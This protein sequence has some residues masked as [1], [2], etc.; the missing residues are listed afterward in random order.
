MSSL[1]EEEN[2]IIPPV[3]PKQN[4]ILTSVDN[5]SHKFGI[6]YVRACVR[7]LHHTV[8]VIYRSRSALPRT[9]FFNRVSWSTILVYTLPKVS[10]SLQ[11]TCTWL[12]VLE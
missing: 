11:E 10:L 12:T 2:S 8:L 9:L 3:C 6:V 5:Y 1:L 4:L 7:A